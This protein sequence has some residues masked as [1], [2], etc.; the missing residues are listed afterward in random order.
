MNEQRKLGITYL[1]TN[2]EVNP[3][4]FTTLAAKCSAL[5][6]L[7]T[8]RPVRYDR[9]QESRYEHHGVATGSRV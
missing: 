1:T 5:H 3:A 9:V 2:S 6:D 8:S 4:T 7:I